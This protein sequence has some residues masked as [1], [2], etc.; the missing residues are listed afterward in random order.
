MFILS[1]KIMKTYL[2]HNR[3][4]S[5][6]REAL[7]ILDKSWKKYVLVEYLKSPLD[8]EALKDLQKKLSI[9]AIEFCRTDEKEFKENGLNKNSTDDEILKLMA[10]FP[11][12]M[13]R[14]IFVDWNKAVLCRPPEKIKDLL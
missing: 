9:K 13:Q 10:R 1:K 6:S 2:L 3:R 7:E 14:A 4:C 12:L 8:F 5:K 11:N